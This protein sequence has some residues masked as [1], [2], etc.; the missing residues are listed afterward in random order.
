VKPPIIT[1]G[2]NFRC[3]YHDAS[4]SISFLLLLM[5]PW[6]MRVYP[7]AMSHEFRHQR[8]SRP[9]NI[10]TGGAGQEDGDAFEVLWTTPSTSRNPCDDLALG[11]FVFDRLLRRGCM[12]PTAT[13]STLHCNI[14]LV[15]SPKHN[16][17]LHEFT[18]SLFTL[19]LRPIPDDI[20]AP[21]SVNLPLRDCSQ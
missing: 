6:L 13:L 10:V 18:L 1:Q 9:S 7:T 14:D 8:I 5:F 19:V 17:I 3:S 15:I 21:S 20:A 12:D 16:N 11:H 2:A 4:I